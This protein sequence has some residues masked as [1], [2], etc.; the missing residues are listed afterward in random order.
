MSSDA[1]ADALLVG[2]RLLWYAGLVGVI[3]AC[4]F[5]LLLAR[6][7]AFGASGERTAGAIGLIA[8]AVLLAGALARLYAQA[9]VSFGIEEPLTPGLLWLVAT[10]LP[11][12]STGWQLQLGA[13]AFAAAALGLVRAGGRAAWGAAYVASL[14]VAATAP[15][16]GHAVSQADRPLLPVA[17]QAGHVLGAGAWI[18]GLF[19]VSV[20]ALRRSGGPAPVA[21]LV[22]AFSPLA[23]AAVVLLALTGLGTVV[24]YLTAPSDLWAT[25]Y[26]RTLFLKILLFAAVATM[27]LV[28]WR[29]VRPRLAG[30]DGVDLL[31]RTAGIELALAGFVLLVTAVLV[32]LP[33]PGEE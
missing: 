30:R 14:A 19:A 27:G 9:Y 33:R 26:G 32:G 20:A 4:A 10:D 24:L 17:L 12:W 7:A 15:L 21:A 22:H 13:G 6:A 23:I 29:V 28:N 2:S 11:P 31:R 16:T 8:A 18:G 1:L 25:G 5:R 3:G